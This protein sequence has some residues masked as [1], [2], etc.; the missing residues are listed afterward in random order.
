[1]TCDDLILK[2]AVA[3]IRGQQGPRDYTFDHRRLWCF[4]Q[5]ECQAIRVR[6]TPDLHGRTFNVLVSKADGLGGKVTQ[7]RVRSRRR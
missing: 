4:Y 5:A 1:M 2:V 6:I 3:R 7:L